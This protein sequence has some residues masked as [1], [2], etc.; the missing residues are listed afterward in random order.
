MEVRPVGKK[1]LLK[2]LEPKE[3]FA[4]TSIYI[5][6]AQREEECKGYVIAVGKDV[7]EIKSGDLIQY[8]DYANPVEMQH[9]G[10]KHLLV[11]SGEVL[12]VLV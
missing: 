2:Q 1:V 4:G 8:A 12:A 5:P 3:T 6:D 7:E 11:S 9:N 10:E